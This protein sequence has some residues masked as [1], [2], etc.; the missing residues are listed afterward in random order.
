LTGPLESKKY[1]AISAALA[2]DGL[3]K[4]F[5][6]VGDR[7]IIGI[8]EIG[9]SIGKLAHQNGRAERDDLAVDVLQCM[10]WTFMSWG[11]LRQGIS[12]AVVPSK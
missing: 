10:S 8:V 2:D 3:G 11:L 6:L 9:I 4:R 12:L 1:T 7:L 5:P